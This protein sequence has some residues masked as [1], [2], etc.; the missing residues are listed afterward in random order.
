MAYLSSKM[1]VR[2]AILA[3]ARA[4]AHET[5]AIVPDQIRETMKERVKAE[6]RL[7]G[8]LLMDLPERDLN[9]IKRAMRD[10]RVHIMSLPTLREMY[11]RNMLR[12]RAEIQEWFKQNEFEQVDMK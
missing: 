1:S 12:S 9:E 7:A 2:S 10:M 11:R 5:M 8:H 4:R 3:A 6:D